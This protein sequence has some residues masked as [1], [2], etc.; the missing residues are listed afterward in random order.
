VA[1]GLA[2]V[3]LQAPAIRLVRRHRDVRLERSFE[4]ALLAM[5]LNQVLD[6]LGVACIGFGHVPSVFGYAGPERVPR[7]GS[8]TRAF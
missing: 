3:L 2:E 6:Q 7:L 5:R 1:L 8:D 4:L